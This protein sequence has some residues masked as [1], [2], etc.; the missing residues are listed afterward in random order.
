MKAFMQEKKEKEKKREKK[1]GKKRKKIEEKKK[2]A[3]KEEKA[4][5]EPPGS[6]P[7]CL[8]DVFC[9]KRSLAPW[10]GGPRGE[11]ARTPQRSRDA[12]P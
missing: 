6:P 9:R 3:R 5:K 1:R 12:P 2:K 4:K 7:H 11:G 10:P 8:L